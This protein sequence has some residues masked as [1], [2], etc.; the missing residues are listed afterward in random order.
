M[1]AQYMYMRR[2]SGKEKGTQVL[3]YVPNR[4]LFPARGLDVHGQF[5]HVSIKAGDL[6]NAAFRNKD[7]PSFTAA[8]NVEQLD[9][10]R[11]L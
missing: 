10:F 2:R 7:I 9:L 1:K 4:M 3:L 11:D 6:C 8:S 5:S